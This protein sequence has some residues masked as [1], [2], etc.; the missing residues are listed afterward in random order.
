MK[1]RRD[2]RV[3]L[4]NTDLVLT[5]L[6]LEDAGEYDCEVESDREVPVSIRH[7]LDVLYPP[8]VQPDPVSGGK[9]STTTTAKCSEEQYSLCEL[10]TVR[11][12]DGRTKCFVVVAL[13]QKNIE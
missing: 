10:I 11:R 4:T 9:D 1:V 2:P 3:Q 12:Q 6:Q 7:R 8:K 5:D 13:R